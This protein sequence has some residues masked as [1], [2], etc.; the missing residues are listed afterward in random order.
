MN[1][2]L[3]TWN[4]EL[5]TIDTALLMAGVLDAKQY[6]DTADPGD[7]QIRALAD[8]LYH[9]VDWDFMR[10]GGNGI[11]MGWKPG[12]GFAASATGSATTR[13]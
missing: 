12:T 7:V 11:R 10:S 3:R 13:P 9:R 6:F 4:C 1:S 2:G 8:S 5:S